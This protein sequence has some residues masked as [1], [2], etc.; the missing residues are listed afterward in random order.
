MEICLKLFEQSI[1]EPMLNGC[2][3]LIFLLIDGLGPLA[4]DNFVDL[5]GIQVHSLNK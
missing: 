5:G 2:A 1:D 3:E 4:A